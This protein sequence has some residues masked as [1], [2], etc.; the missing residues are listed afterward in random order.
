LIVLRP[1]AQALQSK[2]RLANRYSMLL[3]KTGSANRRQASNL[4]A[5]PSINHYILKIAKA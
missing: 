5:L 4:A 1:S 2:K 3:S